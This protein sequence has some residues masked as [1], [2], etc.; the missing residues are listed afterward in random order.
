MDNKLDLQRYHELK[1]K[2]IIYKAGDCFHCSRI[3][4]HTL[5]NP[6]E[7][8]RRSVWGMHDRRVAWELRRGCQGV[9]RRLLEVL[10]VD[11]KDVVVQGNDL[12][13]QLEYGQ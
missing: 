7:I 5:P 8:R 4:I 1:L 11:G 9:S 3:S 2:A 12:Q 6:R 10:L 13:K